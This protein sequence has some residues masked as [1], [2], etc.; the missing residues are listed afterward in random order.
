MKK[1]PI[2]VIFIT[3][4]LDLLG[5]GLIIPIL[6]LFSQDLGASSLTVGL[7][8]AIYSLMNFIFAPIWGSLSDIYGRRPVILFSVA[9]T[10]VSYLLFG[11]THSLIVLFISRMLAGIGSANISVAQAYISDI[12]KPEDRAKSMGLIGAAFGLGF[13]FGPLFGGIL[14]ADF[15]T[16][17][18]GLAAASLSTFNFVLAYFL[19]PESLINKIKNKKISLFALAG[20]NDVLRRKNISSLFFINFIYVTAFTMMQMTA[21]LMWKDRF[22]LD[23][24]HSGYMFAFI[25]LISAITQGGLIG[26]LN[27][28]LGEKKLIVIGL[29]CV[30]IG[31]FTIPFA[32]QIFPQFYFVQCLS[33]ALLAFGS[34]CAT[35]TISALLSKLSK[36]NEQG[37]VLGLNM[38]FASLS[39]VVGPILGGWLYSFYFGFP[40]WGASIIM[41]GC[42]ALLI[43]LYRRMAK[44]S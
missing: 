5:F 43:P 14:K 33:M 40:F 31:L 17:A 28:K 37:E 44:D 12:T 34:G 26:T 19:L 38:S 35:P 30:T 32:P 25:G 3:V 27:K 39:R 1:S 9:I 13:I 29:S 24:K 15:G 23:E 4:F 2:L 20:F 22:G 11:F 8:A 10:A 18:L 21:V 16:V 42:F 7:I 41:L 36:A 6:P